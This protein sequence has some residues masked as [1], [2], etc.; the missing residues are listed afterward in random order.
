VTS[1]MPRSIRPKLATTYLAGSVDPTDA[2]CAEV[3]KLV[4]F[5]SHASQ[6]DQDSE[7]LQPEQ[8]G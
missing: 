7:P 8:S 1:W 6:Q 2:C 3:K 5:R 4:G